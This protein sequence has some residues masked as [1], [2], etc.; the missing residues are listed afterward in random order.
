[1]ALADGVKT[2]MREFAKR[3][4]AKPMLLY[5]L[6]PLSGA[7]F[8]GRRLNALSTRASAPR[9]RIVQRTGSPRTASPCE[10]AATLPLAHFTALTSFL[11]RRLKMILAGNLASASPTSS[12]VKLLR[13]WV[14]A[15]IASLTAS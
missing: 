6:G 13:D 3:H 14:R 4:M 8:I 12:R 2:L 1:V 9:Q 15:A 10:A 5:Y 11:A 7:C